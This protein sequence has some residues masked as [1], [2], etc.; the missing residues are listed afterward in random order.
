MKGIILCDVY[1]CTCTCIRAHTIFLLSNDTRADEM[2]TQVH[3]AYKSVD[4]HL[5]Q[6][7]TRTSTTVPPMY[8]SKWNH[9]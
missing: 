3:D 2:D 1:V 4:S 9:T 8:F 6:R 7:K 5:K